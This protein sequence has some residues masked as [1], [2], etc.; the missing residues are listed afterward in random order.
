MQSD[1]LIFQKIEIGHF[2]NSWN[3]Y[4]ISGNKDRILYG[5]GHNPSVPQIL[6]EYLGAEP[7]FYK[8]IGPDDKIHGLLQACI[9]NNK[10]YSLPVFPVSGIYTQVNAL[11][12]DLYQ[13]FLP[14]VSR[15]EIRDFTRI[16]KYALTSKFLYYLELKTDPEDQLAFFR[17]KLRSQIVKGLSSNFSKITGKSDL[18]DSFYPVYSENMRRIGSPVIEKRF[19]QL[20]LD[21]YQHGICKIILIQKDNK[22]VGCSI[23]LSYGKLMEVGWASTDPGYNKLNVNMVLYWEMIRYAIENQMHIFSFGRATRNSGSY[24]FKKQWQGE[25][26]PIYFNY[27]SRKINFRNFKVFRKLWQLI[28]QQAADKLGPVIR[29]RVE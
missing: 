12:A 28:P 14:S 5:I 27:D 23:I 25:F 17:S 9:V 15:F 8:I 11:K 1:N 26:I 20:L 21:K 3:Q 19:F 22:T 10:F 13:K 24:N 4:I 7:V 16:S 2:A 6:S 29:K 18:L